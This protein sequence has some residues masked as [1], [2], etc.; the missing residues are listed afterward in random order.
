VETAHELAGSRLLVGRSVHEPEEALRAA[1]AGADYVTFGHVFPTNSKPGLPPRGIQM[2]ADIVAA[3]DVPVLA[4]G[5]INAAN[6]NE[7][8]ATGCAGIALISAILSAK[9]PRQAA[10]ELRTALDASPHQ[11][12][13]PF[14]TFSPQEKSHATDRQPTAV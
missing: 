12:H 8:L 5:G 3:L 10:R 14:P 11:P 2:L 4:I 9:E 1:E 6:L 13:R 7:V